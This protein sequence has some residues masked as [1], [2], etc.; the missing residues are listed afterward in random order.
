MMPEINAAI[1]LASH[2]L[3]VSIVVKAT[4]T[5]ALALIAV[6]LARGSRASLRHVM[7]TVAFGVLLALPAASLVL[8]AVA[9]AVRVAPPARPVRSRSTG[10][11]RASSRVAPLPSRVEPSRSRGVSAAVVLFPIW[12]LGSMVFLLPMAAG[13]R[14]LRSFRRSGVEWPRGQSIADG[15]ARKAGIGRRVAVLRQDAVPG[16]MTCGVLRPVIVLPTDAQNWEH[17]DLQRAIVHELEHVRR[18]DWAIQ[19]LARA[20]CSFY[21]FLPL[22]WMAWRELALEAER[23][24]DDAVLGSFEATAYADQLVELA[25]RQSRVARSPVLAMASRADLTKRVGALLDHRQRRGRVGL[26]FVAIACAAAAALLVTMSPLTLVAAPQAASAESDATGLYSVTNALVIADVTVRDANGEDIGG[27]TAGDFGISEDG[28]AQT[29]S[30]FESQKLVTAPP[31]S[32]VR[33][34]YILGYYTTN[35]KMDGAYRK[36]N[37]SLKPKRSGTKLQFRDGY[38]SDKAIPVP[39]GGTTH[40]GPFPVLLSK[41]EAEYS[42]EARKAKLQG[43]VLLDVQVDTSGHPINMIVSR[44]LGSGLDEK[45]MEAVSHWVFQAPTKNGVPVFSQIL[46]AVNFRLL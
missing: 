43:T 44:S 13:L 26:V 32:K 16:P 8:P 35:L 20:I 27:L 33:S 25:T 28:V 4:F 30:V 14:Q 37:V 9:I 6:R 39:S 10:I 12:I 18:G 11:T 5:T 36:L 34:Y 7:L 38:Y 3:A 24:C 1:L 41:T 2:S 21:W 22:A 45:A 29:I 23:S 17:D 31:E 19:C 40:T 15:L 42:V 46:A